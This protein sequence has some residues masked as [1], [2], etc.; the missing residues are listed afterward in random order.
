MDFTHF[1]FDV[2]YCSLDFETWIHDDNTFE[3]GV[4]SPLCPIEDFAVTDNQSTGL[5]EQSRYISL[6]FQNSEFDVTYHGARVEKYITTGDGDLS[7]LC[8]S[9]FN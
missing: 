8:H 9:H 6:S 2:Q 1:P 7:N 4:P 3:T 5:R